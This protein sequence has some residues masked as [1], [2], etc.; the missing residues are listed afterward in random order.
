MKYFFFG[1][2][3]R[4]HIQFI[5]YACAGGSAA[6]L[7]LLFFAIAVEHFHVQYLVAAFFTYVFGFAWM[8]FLSVYWI[9]ESRH[10]RTSE[11]FMAFVI[12]LFG[13]LWMEILL[14]TFVERFLLDVIIAKVLS[15]LLVFFWNFGIRKLYVFH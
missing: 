10:G 12:T 11:F 2:Q 3:R 7:D 14:Y 15:Q 4:M 6:L 13:L 1:K 5:R 8:H 9:F